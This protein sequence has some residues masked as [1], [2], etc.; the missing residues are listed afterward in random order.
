M[1]SAAAAA[2]VA[3]QRW[4]LGRMGGRHSLQKPLICFIAARGCLIEG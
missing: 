4:K 2:S 1:A 3:A